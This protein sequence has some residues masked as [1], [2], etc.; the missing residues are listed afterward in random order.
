[1]VVD[2]AEQ[3]KLL[4]CSVERVALAQV[5]S[6]TGG[7]SVSTTRRSSLNDEREEVLLSSSSVVVHKQKQFVP[8]R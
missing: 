2:L 8:L 4:T 1:M 5:H 3:V 6:V 7:V